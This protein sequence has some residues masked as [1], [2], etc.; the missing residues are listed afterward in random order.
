M[1]ASTM[2][3][4]MLRP[5]VCMSHGAQRKTKMKKKIAKILRALAKEVDAGKFGD[6]GGHTN[7]AGRHVDV[8]LDERIKAAA[9]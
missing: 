4:S 1:A 8:E 5:N 3:G 7:K 9:K 2:C 6:D